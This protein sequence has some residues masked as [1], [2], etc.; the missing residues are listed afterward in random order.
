MNDSWR[1]D[2]KQNAVVF[3]AAY[4]PTETAREV[5]KNEFWAG[6][7]STI[8]RVPVGEP[9]FVTIEAKSALERE[10]M[11]VEKAIVRC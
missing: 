7:H 11:Q 4:T 10:R 2:G 1:S 9:I 3:V 8:A 6:L 5:D